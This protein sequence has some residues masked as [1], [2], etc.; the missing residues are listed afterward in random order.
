MHILFVPCLL[1]C[2]FVFC[3]YSNAIV[4]LKQVHR[5]GPGRQKRFKANTHSLPTPSMY[6]PDRPDHDHIATTPSSHRGPTQDHSTTLTT[7]IRPIVHGTSTTLDYLVKRWLPR[8]TCKSLDQSSIHD[9][10]SLGSMEV[11]RETPTIL[12]ANHA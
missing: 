1:A 5:L 7:H 11:A 10:G 4:L 6:H 3:I 12:S 9:N 2:H 8:C